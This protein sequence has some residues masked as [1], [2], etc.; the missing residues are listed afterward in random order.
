MESPSLLSIQSMISTNNNNTDANMNENFHSWFELIGTL[1]FDYPINL[2]KLTKYFRNNWQISIYYSALYLILVLI[3][4]R[5]MKNRQPYNLRL[6]LAIWSGT[7]SLFSMVGT[8]NTWPEFVKMFWHNGFVS[9]YCNNSYIDDDNLIFW[10]TIFSLSK[11]LELFDTAFIVLRK[12]NLLTLHWIHHILTF[13]YTFYIFG[14]KAATA[15]WMVTMNLAVHSVMYGYYALRAMKISI[16]R[17]IAMAIT[18]AQIVQMIFG[19]IIHGHITW[20]KLFSKQQQCDCPFNGIIYGLLMYLLYFYFFV[21]FFID[22]YFNKPTK[23]TKQSKENGEIG[24]CQKS[25]TKEYSSDK[26]YIDD[27]IN[28]NINHLQHHDRKMKKFQ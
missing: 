5:W 12:Q 23:T 11:L 4:T 16:P 1:F 28:N 13:V 26:C 9:T 21:Q 8:I 3:G 15:R 18:G 14:F 10:Y 22:S 7:L 19:L 25:S 27:I 20:L 17:Q 24:Y 2:E 6:L